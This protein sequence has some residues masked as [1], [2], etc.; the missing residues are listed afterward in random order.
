MPAW[1]WVG[2]GHMRGRVR[3]EGEVPEEG[4]GSEGE[5]RGGG[6]QG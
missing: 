2:L 6:G 4:G 5:V 1:V 3:G